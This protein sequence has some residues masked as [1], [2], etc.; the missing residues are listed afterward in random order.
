M[1]NNNGEKNQNV[2]MTF[3]T[4]EMKIIVFFQPR[5]PETL[6]K[7]QQLTFSLFIGYHLPVTSS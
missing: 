4:E 5:H 1:V 3:V 2:M 6:K 7:K